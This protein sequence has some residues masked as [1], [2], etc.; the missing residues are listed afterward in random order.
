MR[1]RIIAFSSSIISDLNESPPVLISFRYFSFSASAFSN[2]TSMG[3]SEGCLINVLI[4]LPPSPF[5]NYIKL[6]FQYTS[7]LLFIA[8][9]F[10][11]VE[12][13]FGRA[14]EGAQYMRVNHCCL[15]VLM[16]QQLL[17]LSY[18][19]TV[20]KKVRGKTVAQRVNGCM[21]LNPGLFNGIL[22]DILN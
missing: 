19:D 6:F 14:G 20:H 13:A 8:F 22:D 12:R 2:C 16:A 17:H 11:A 15:Q 3:I 21:F 5:T 18:I 9:I 7:A 10:H 4:A 1:T